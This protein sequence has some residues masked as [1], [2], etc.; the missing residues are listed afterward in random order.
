MMDACRVLNYYVCLSIYMYG[1][2]RI[3]L[4]KEDSM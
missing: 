2:L 4:D 1:K 3:L